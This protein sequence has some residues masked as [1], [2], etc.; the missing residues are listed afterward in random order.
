M[1]KVGGR[2]EPGDDDDAAG[3]LRNGEEQDNRDPSRW[4]EE[5]WEIALSVERLSDRDVRFPQIILPTNLSSD[6]LTPCL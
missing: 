6:F 1:L 2:G 3:L 5:R 4:P